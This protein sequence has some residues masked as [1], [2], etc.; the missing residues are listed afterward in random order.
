MSKYNFK[1]CINNLLELYKTTN[2]KLGEFENRIGV[3]SG[4][5][6]RLLKNETT[7]GNI[8]VE[9]LFNASEIL[10]I[11][12]DILGCDNLIELD[13][14]EKYMFD[15]LKKMLKNTNDDKIEWKYYKQEDIE[16]ST[17][18]LSLFSSNYNDFCREYVYHFESGFWNDKDYQV[19]L[20]DNLLAFE[21]EDGLFVLSKVNVKSYEEEFDSFELYFKNF[22]ENDATKIL[23]SSS[24]HKQPLN[25]IFELIYSA[26]KINIQKIKISTD[27]K[28]IIDKFM[29]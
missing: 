21:Q 7:S 9:A 23:C 14:T 25:H 11:P 24:K 2:L 28:K 18:L 10:G 29:N 8:N 19:N 15:F 17:H 1:I 13:E 12:V 6:S 4:Y 16:K 22:N 3:S 20:I 5:F 26:V 27:V